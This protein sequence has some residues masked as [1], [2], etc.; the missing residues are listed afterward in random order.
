LYPITEVKAVDVDIQGILK[1]V[2]R[3][4]R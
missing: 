2:W 1:A 3:S 4:V